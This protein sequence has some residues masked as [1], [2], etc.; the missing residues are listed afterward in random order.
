MSTYTL[1]ASLGEDFR[2]SAIF[3]DN[4]TE[5]TFNAINEI[6]GKAHRNKTGP[7]ALGE[8][9]LLSPSGELLREM[10]AK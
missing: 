5:A 7:W 8:I 4:D 10:P 9:K 3:A 2:I 1:T 6:M